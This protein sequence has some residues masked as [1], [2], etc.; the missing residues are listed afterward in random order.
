M[1]IEEIRKL[2]AGRELDALIDRHVF[3]RDKTA[4]CE[5]FSANRCDGVKRTICSA[6]GGF[7]HGNCYGYGRGG[8]I[9]IQCSDACCGYDYSSDIAA[10]WMVVQYFHPDGTNEGYSVQL[11]GH[12]EGYTFHIFKSATD[13]NNTAALAPLAI[14]RAALIAVTQNK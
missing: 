2:E 11:D 9:Q 6:C 5:T 14:C 1:T 7:G 12:G 13:Y 3:G 10:A 8:E 4:Y